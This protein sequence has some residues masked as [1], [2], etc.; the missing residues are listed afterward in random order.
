MH[1]LSSGLNSVQLENG[2]NPLEGCHT[3]TTYSL[4][5]TEKDIKE[6]D[7]EKGRNTNPILKY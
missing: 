4:L 7:D 2:Y 1:D 5:L 6:L 3:Y